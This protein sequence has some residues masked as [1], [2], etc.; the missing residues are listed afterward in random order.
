[1]LRHIL[2]ATLGLMLFALPAQA[3]DIVLGLSRDS[4]QIT[5]NFSGTELLIYGA[6]RREAAIPDDPMGLILT[7]AGP[8]EE[9]TVYKKDRVAGIWVNTENVTIEAAPA[10][11]AVASN[12]PL[13]DILSKGADRRHAVSINRAIRSIWA[14]VT[15]GDV[16]AFV[17]AVIRIRENKGLYRLEESAVKIDDETLFSARVRMPADLTEG[18]YETRIFL[19]RGGE[20]VSK[21]TRDI[22]VRKVGLERFLYNLSREQPLVYGLMS[23]AIATFAGWAASAAFRA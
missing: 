10:F 13:D 17:D 23:L 6:I 8:S 7:V 19:T 11:Y 5:T 4:I 2:R 3:E 14:R 12:A 16:G 9:V 18:R 21:Y 22:D 20:V 1:M 15:H